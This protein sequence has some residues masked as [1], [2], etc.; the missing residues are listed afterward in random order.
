MYSWCITSSGIV[1][2]KLLCLPI[3]Y[4]NN[5]ECILVA[6]TKLSKCFLIIVDI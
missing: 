3:V 5:V 6:S 4:D 1:S 2:T